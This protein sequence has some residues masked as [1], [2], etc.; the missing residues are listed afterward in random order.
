MTFGARRFLSLLAMALIP[1]LLF[2]AYRYDAGRRV[3]DMRDL[4]IAQGVAVTDVIAE[5]SRHGL[6]LYNRWRSDTDGGE[7]TANGSAGGDLPAALGPGRLIRTLGRSEGVR[8]VVLQDGRDIQAA[9]TGRVTFPALADDPVMQPLLEGVPYVTRERD[10]ELGPVLE[11]ARILAPG[12]GSGVV[13]RV[14]LDSTL[15]EQ[16]RDDMRRRSILRAVVLI[17][18]LL[19]FSSLLLAWQRQAVLHRE[20]QRVTGELRRKEEELRRGEKLAAMGTLAAGVAHQVRNP[21]NSIHMIAQMLGRRPEL[22]E[23]VRQEIGHITEESGRI[24]AI[25]Q[26][27]LQFTRPREPEYSTFDLAAAV[28]DAV[29]VQ[30]AA[31]AGRDVTFEVEAASIPVE[32]DRQFVVE[33]LENLLRNAV[34]AM[35]DGGRVRV[36]AR[37]A[38]AEA[39]IQ[40]ADDGPGID[41]G[42]RRRIFDLYYTTRPQGSGLGLS[43][44]T[45]MIAAQGGTLEVADEA[46]LDG[47][48][49]RFVIRLPRERSEG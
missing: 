10:T 21:L 22:P 25:V 28:R 1:V 27:F 20:V 48:G 33:V 24:E 31:A 19:V 43:L 38:G 32:L 44:A 2:F 13:L 6:E 14:G 18:S 39:E 12:G 8:Y 37:T 49:A 29:D 23:Q 34:E 41:P 4:M 40:V 26:Q 30:A 7:V 45:Q 35:D 3:D 9:S 11:V 36:E 16:M 17:A 46:G 47:Q 42:D 15:L 5:S